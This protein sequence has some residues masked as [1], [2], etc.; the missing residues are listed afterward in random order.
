[1]IGTLRGILAC[2]SIEPETLAA[3][4]RQFEELGDADRNVLDF[5]LE[6]LVWRDGI[7]RMF[8]DDGNGHGRIPRV[9]IP[10]WQ[11]LPEPFKL[12]IDPLTPGQNPDLLSLDRHQTTRCAEAFLNH[13]ETAA[14][15]TPWEFHN[16]PNGVKGVLNRLIQENVYVGLLGNACLGTIELPWRARADLDALVAT[17]AVIRYRTEHGEYPDSLTQLV[18]TGFLRR[19]PADP[20]ADGPLI[21][22]RGEGGFLLYSHGRDFDDDGGV[23]SRWGDGPDGGDQ[24]FWP[25]R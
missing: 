5:T 4:Q 20:Y 22:Q 6:R 16:E 19:V 10:E 17:I 3:M 14:A 15:K 13:V 21:Y 7:Q 25:V 12:L 2:E 9:A 1:M 24:L 8:T 23:P 18:E 11:G